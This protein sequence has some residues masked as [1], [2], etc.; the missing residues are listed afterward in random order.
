MRFDVLNRSNLWSLYTEIGTH[1]DHCRLYPF[2]AFSIVLSDTS[3][4][5]NCLFDIRG[6]ERPGSH[7]IDEMHNRLSAYE[8]KALIISADNPDFDL[9]LRKS[10]YNY[11]PIEQWT[12]MCRNIRPDETFTTDGGGCEVVTAGQPDVEEWVAV[13]SDALF[14]GKILSIEIFS[15]LYGAGHILVALKKEG[16]II[17]TA[18]IFFDQADIAGIYMFSVKKEFRGQ[19]LGRIILGYCLEWIRLSG[20]ETC[21]L[22]STRAGLRLYAKAGFSGSN[23]YSLFWKIK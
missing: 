9:R 14:N 10:P 12:G 21:I 23:L 19:G 3:A 17:G 18:L 8:A 11:Y 5:P 15:H 7:L 16:M 6:T 4:W 22:Q 20:R 2:A 1:V 13:V